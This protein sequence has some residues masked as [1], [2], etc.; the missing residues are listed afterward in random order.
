[1]QV[2]SNIWL[3]KIG[4]PALYISVCMAV[5]VSTP[6]LPPS[7]IGSQV[8]LTNPHHLNREPYLLRLVL[9]ITLLASCALDFS[10][11]LWRQLF[12]LVHIGSL[13][14]P[15]SCTN[16]CHYSPAACSLLARGTSARSLAREWLSFIPGPRF[17]VLSPA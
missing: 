16:V 12:T 8:P 3:N 5:W 13:R 17:Q 9:H 15:R 1:M 11:D 10:L 6:Y 4:K 14:T 2:P 7:Q